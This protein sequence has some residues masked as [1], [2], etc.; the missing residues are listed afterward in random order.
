MI[1]RRRKAKPK[2]QA[3]SLADQPQGVLNIYKSM[4][5]RTS[6]TIEEEKARDKAFLEFH[7]R[8]SDLNRQHELRMMEMMMQFSRYQQVMSPM[9]VLKAWH[10]VHFQKYLLVLILLC[11]LVKLKALVDVVVP[12]NITVPMLTILPP[13]ENHM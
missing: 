12:T 3:Q 13:M 4:E 9:E 1:P 6:R 2:S 7:D 5:E 8:Q 11:F 10:I